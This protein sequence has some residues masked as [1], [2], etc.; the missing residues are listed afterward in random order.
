MKDS[1]I[2]FLLSLALLV[3]LAVGIAVGKRICT[4]SPLVLINLLAALAVSAYWAGKWY[5]YLFQGIQW[6]A[7]D[8]WLPL[9]ALLV[10]G[11]C[12]AYYAGRNIHAAV[13]WGIFFIDLAAISFA[14]LFF[15]FFKINKLF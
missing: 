5:S 15:V 10:C 4:L 11:L 1:S 2:V 8:Q 9:C 13:F 6:Y 12:I 3:H 14:L 7:A